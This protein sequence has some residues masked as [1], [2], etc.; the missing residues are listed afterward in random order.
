MPL[1]HTVQREFQPKTAPTCS[2]DE[3]VNWKSGSEIKFHQVKITEE[4][5]FCRVGLFSQSDSSMTLRMTAIIP[6]FNS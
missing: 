2:E 5:S 4:I 3:Y 6:V 1:S